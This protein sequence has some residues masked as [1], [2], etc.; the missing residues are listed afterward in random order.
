MEVFS[1]AELSEETKQKM[2]RIACE[3][4][5]LL[6]INHCALEHGLISEWAFGEMERKIHVRSARKLNEL[7]GK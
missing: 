4:A 6:A 3:E 7:K 5:E 2:M 1:L